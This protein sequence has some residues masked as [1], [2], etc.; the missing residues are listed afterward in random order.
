MLE[1]RTFRMLLALVESLVAAFFGG[2]GLAQRAAILNQSFLGTTLWNTTASSHVWPW[3]YKFASILNMPALLAGL[4]LTI[5]AA[6]MT[7]RLSET[8][9]LLPT[10]FLVFVLWFWIGSHL[11]RY[12]TITAKA[13]WIALTVF[14][15]ACLIGAIIP[16]GNTGYLLYGIVLWLIGLF[17]L[18]SAKPTSAP[19]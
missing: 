12:W 7:P 15:I 2:W 4:L 10:L 5:P 14:T 17:L 13:P 8:L 18:R 3:P 6:H 16:I 19:A 11:D 9:Q 1:T